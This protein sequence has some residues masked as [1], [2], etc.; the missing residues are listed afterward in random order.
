MKLDACKKATVFLGG[1]G[2]RKAPFIQSQ[3]TRNYL[4]YKKDMRTKIFDARPTRCGGI[5]RSFLHPGLL[6]LRRSDCRPRISHDGVSGSIGET[7]GCVEQNDLL[8]GRARIQP[9]QNFVGSCVCVR[10]SAHRGHEYARS[11]AGIR[12]HQAGY[13]EDRNGF[14]GHYRLTAFDIT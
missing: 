14:L 4:Q 9:E 7:P 12:L 13:L 10:S 3:K 5:R 8:L 1:S 2:W 11:G 6:Q